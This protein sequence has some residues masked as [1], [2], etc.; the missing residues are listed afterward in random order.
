MVVQDSLIIQGQAYNWSALK[1]KGALQIGQGKGKNKNR[2]LKMGGNIKI[3][4]K[5]L[6]KTNFGSLVRK[7][8]S[9]GSHSYPF[10]CLIYPWYLSFFLQ[11]KKKTYYILDSTVW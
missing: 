4:G 1:K 8:K 11:K 2:L 5:F 9:L 3:T 10:I 7:K 6:A